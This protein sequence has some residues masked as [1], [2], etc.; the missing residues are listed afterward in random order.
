MRLTP[1]IIDVIHNQRQ[2]PVATCSYAK[3]ADSASIPNLVYVS[4]LK[5]YDE[6][7]ILIADNKF[8][9]TRM[10]LEKNPRIAIT[11]YDPDTNKSYQVKG[12][13]SIIE[14]GPVYEET[15]KW[16]QGRKPNLTPKAAVLVHID[17]IYSKDKKLVWDQD[18]PRFIKGMV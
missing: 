17:E 7:T 9:K 14:S 13:A 11:V 10:N 1:E 2:I 3:D 6:K 15:V 12:T 5:V 16:V 4:F 8:Y 18:I